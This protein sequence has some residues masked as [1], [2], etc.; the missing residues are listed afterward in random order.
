MSHKHSRGDIAM[1]IIQPFRRKNSII[2]P[3]D[4]VS[5]AFKEQAEL[6][7]EKAKQDSPN[8]EESKKASSTI[9]DK[10]DFLLLENIVC[11]DARGRI[12]EQYKA[13]EVRKDIF[14]RKRS[15]QNFTP[16]EAAV[17]CEQ[18]GLF[19]PSFALSCNILTALYQGKSDPAIAKVLGQYKSYSRYCYGGHTTN[20]LIEWGSAKI[21]NYPKDSDFPSNGGNQNIN[22]EWKRKELS[23]LSKDLSDMRLEDALKLNPFMRFIQ[24]LTGLPDPSI[25]VKIGGYFQK[26][27]RVWV[28]SSSE[29]RAAWLGCNYYNF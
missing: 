19:L 9:Q 14:R 23:F 2:V 7:K 12:F 11:K 21:I 3:L 10:G 13:L 27:A 1:N 28:S 20:T 25:L 6:G 5:E 17:Y 8:A 22:G 29:T 15:P 16:C 26:E 24:N 18:Q 4:K